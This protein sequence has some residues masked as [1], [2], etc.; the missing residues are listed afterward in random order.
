[1]PRFFVDSLSDDD[2]ILRGEEAA[3]LSRSL[4]MREGDAV[5]LC[6]GDGLDAEAVIRHIADREVTLHILSRAPSLTE[7]RLAV[8]L[9]QALPK[10][11][12]LETIIQKATEIGVHEIRPFLSRYCVSR[13]KDFDKKLGRLRKISA[14]AAKQS[15]RGRVPEVQPLLDFADLCCIMSNYDAAILCYEGATTPLAEAL[16]GIHG[17]SRIALIIGSEGGFSAEEAAS[18]QATGALSCSLGPRI[19]RCETAPVA[20]LSAILFAAGEF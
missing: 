5:T 1:M 17:W 16:V 20:A 9:F 12:K 7:P 6:D 10:F 3:H 4:R 11:D 19:L 13:P 2:I 15:G 8:A 18:L 14:E